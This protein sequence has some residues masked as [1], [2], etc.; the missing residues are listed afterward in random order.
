MLKYITIFVFALLSVG[1]D[2]GCDSNTSVEDKT[3]DGLGHIVLN[4]GVADA[5]VEV[6]TVTIEGKKF[7]VAVYAGY[8]VG[9]TQILDK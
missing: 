8:G 1:A 5:N 9:I 7:A 2:N 6:Y 4:R 3:R